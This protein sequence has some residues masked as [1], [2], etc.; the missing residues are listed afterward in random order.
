MILNK[1]K[2]KQKMA[3]NNTKDIKKIVW[4][5]LLQQ[6]GKK[7]VRIES[8]KLK[9]NCLI[10]QY[11]VFGWKDTH[12]RPLALIYNTIFS[13]LLWNVSRCQAT[14]K[15]DLI[16]FHGIWGLVSLISHLCSSVFDFWLYFSGS[17]LEICIWKSVWHSISS[18]TSSESTFELCLLNLHMFF[19]CCCTV[20]FG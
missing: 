19:L 3:Y 1:V 6:K 14:F 17:A 8:S 7:R 9:V 11:T 12:R 5:F 18:W 4:T 10:H 15:P 16:I 13:S 2:H 20:L